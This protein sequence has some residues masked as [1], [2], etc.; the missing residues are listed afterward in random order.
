MPA[1]SRISVRWLMPLACLVLS[2]AAARA[3]DPFPLRAVVFEGAERFVPA[4]LIAVMG[5]ELGHLV[6]KR[7]FDAGLQRLQ[8]TGMF[9]NLSYRFGPQGD[10]YKLVVALRELPDLFPVRFDGFGTDSEVLAALLRETL[11]LYVGVLPHGGPAVGAAV[12]ALQAW[13]R[14]QGG[15][16]DVVADLVPSSSA[17]LEMLIRPE[18]M[19]DN[20]AFVRFENA[21]DVDARELQRVFNSA[22]V[23]EPYSEARLNELLAYNA[24]PFYTERGYMNVEFC[25]CETGPDPDSAG[26]LVNVHVEQGEVYRFGTIAWPEPLPIDPESL[27]KVNQ[28][29]EGFVANLQAAYDTMSAISEGMKRQGYMKAQATFEELVDHDALRVDLDVQIDSGQQYVFSRLIIK[30][31]DILSEP[32]VRKRWGMQPG[33]PFDIRYPAYFLDRVKADAMFENLKRTS[34]TLTI[35]EPNGR[36]DVTLLFSGLA[37]EPFRDDRNE[38]EAPF[39]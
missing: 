13:W 32:T 8:G 25:P 9:E 30:G 4:D 29:E 27:N 31:L 28:I 12:N 24:R 23:G 36:V 39:D 11:P 6:T 34:W 19:A 7:D 5:F 20:I 26:I 38:I 22:A 35:D 10:G 16:E 18:R 15:E 14:S 21:G 33:A 37:D 2:G 3:E 17:D 1:R